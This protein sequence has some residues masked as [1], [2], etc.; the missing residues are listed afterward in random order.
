MSKVLYIKEM[1]DIERTVLGE[2]KFAEDLRRI[3]YKTEKEDLLEALVDYENN[4]NFANVLDTEDDFAEEC[5]GSR[6][7]AIGWENA[8]DIWN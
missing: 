2:V 4:F 8:F 6:I 5:L 3:I 1:C 7:I